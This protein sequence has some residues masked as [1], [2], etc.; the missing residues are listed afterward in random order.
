MPY[1][2][3]CIV[4]LNQTAARAQ[5]L[6]AGCGL[7]EGGTAEVS[8]YYA[9]KMEQAVGYICVDTQRKIRTGNLERPIPNLAFR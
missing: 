2:Q 1:E 4:R 3:S 8:L 5:N 6:L 9:E 7:T